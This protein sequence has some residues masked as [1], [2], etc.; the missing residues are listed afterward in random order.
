MPPAVRLRMKRAIPR[1]APA[2]ARSPPTF[3]PI[4]LSLARVLVVVD[5]V[6][7][8]LRG[9]GPRGDSLGAIVA[10]VLVDL[11]VVG[12][13]KSGWP[14]CYVTKVETS[15]RLLATRKEE[16]RTSSFSLNFLMRASN[17]FESKRSA[18]RL[19]SLLHKP[20]D[21]SDKSKARL[22]RSISSPSWPWTTATTAAALS[23]WWS[24]STSK[25]SWR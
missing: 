18:M 22:H 21:K 9:A 4:S 1:P 14:K 23:S 20:R 3:P 10:I 11:V 8:L 15:D 12:A 6:A 7:R 16:T 2:G 13:K 25:T 17:L 19:P 5:V 24:R